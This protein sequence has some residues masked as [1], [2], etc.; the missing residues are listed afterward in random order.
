MCQSLRTTDWRRVSV[1]GGD[2]GV[3]YRANRLHAEASP[4]PPTGRH[5]WRTATGL[6]WAIYGRIQVVNREKKG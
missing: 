3:G 5:G 2:L 1:S 4:R 6:K